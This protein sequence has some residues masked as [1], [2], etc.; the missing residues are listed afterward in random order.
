MSFYG[1]KVALKKVEAPEFVWP[2][3][4]IGRTEL[5]DYKS[6]PGHVSAERD[7]IMGVYARLTPFLDNI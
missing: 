1:W 7:P 4:L 5:S 3:V 6:C 2:R